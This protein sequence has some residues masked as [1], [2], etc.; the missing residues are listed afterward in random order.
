MNQKSLH[1]VECQMMIRKSVSQVFEAFINPEL[2]T[3]FWFTKSSGPLIEGIQLI[4]EWEMYGV[5]TIIHVKEIIPEN[6]IRIEWG[7]QLTTVEFEFKA[8]DVDKTYVIIKNYGFQLTG[9]E[10]IQAIK[11]STGGFTTVLDGCKAFLEH[12]IA[13]N[14]IADKFPKEISDHG[15]E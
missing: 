12:G 5:S 6:K 14:L 8:L 4:W 1:K 9:D 7:D 3:K 13:L 10:L 11:D 2:T 15:N